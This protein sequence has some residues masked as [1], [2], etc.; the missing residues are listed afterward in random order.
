MTNLSEHRVL[1]INT[2][3]SSLKAALYQ[4]S[5]KQPLVL[6]LEVSRIGSSGSRMRITDA[7]GAMVF[8]RHAETSDHDAA[9]R[10]AFDWLLQ[11]DCLQQMHCVGHRIVHGGSRYSEPQFV[12]PELV[13]ALQE[14]APLVPD[15]LPQAIS[16]IQFVSRAFPVLRQMVCFDTAFHRRMPGLS[17]RYALPR[18]LFDEGLRRFGFHGLSYEYVM[19]ELRRLDGTLADGRVIVAHL[20]SGSS[21]AAIQGGASIDTTIGFTPASGLVMGTRCGDI[22]PEAVL[23]LIEARKMTP[24]AV[25]TLINRQSGLLGV[26]GTSDDVQDLL[27]RESADAHAAEALELFCYRAKKY[28]GAY[29]AALGGLEILVFTGGIGTH[30]AAIRQRMCA[31]L[32]CLGIV[33]DSARNRD[34]APVISGATPATHSRVKVR[35][36]KTDEELTIARH[37]VK[38]LSQ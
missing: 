18:H 16:G 29:V 30:A 12:T 36:L 33:L 8:D 34:N 15:H 17:Q 19:H 31:G 23:Y 26:S 13:A 9:L 21:M 22:D 37:A 11:H 27:D 14:L 4:M 6:S 10:A 2:G 28:L 35:V 5:A 1:A 3:S 38:L 24:Q 20:G 7:G 25:N 32:E